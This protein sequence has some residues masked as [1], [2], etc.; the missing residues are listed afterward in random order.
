MEQRMHFQ[1]SEILKDFGLSVCIG[2]FSTANF[3]EYVGKDLTKTKDSSRWRFT[4]PFRHCRPHLQ[5]P[6][7]NS[8]QKCQPEI[9]GLK[10]KLD[11]INCIKYCCFLSASLAAAWLVSIHRNLRIRGLLLSIHSAHPPPAPNLTKKV[12][13]FVAFLILRAPSA[14]LGNIAFVPNSP[15]F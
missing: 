6:Q 11:K 10:D 9:F 3:L 4:V 15:D 8:H 12:V 14:H 1:A 13:F 7:L 5:Y 2:L